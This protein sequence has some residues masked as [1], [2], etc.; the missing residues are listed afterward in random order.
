MHNVKIYSKLEG[1][2]VQSVHFKALVTYT[3]VYVLF[4]NNVLYEHNENLIE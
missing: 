1:N 4:D 2:M 3:S